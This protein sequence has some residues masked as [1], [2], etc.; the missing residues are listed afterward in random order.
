MRD[1]TTVI[2]SVLASKSH[3]MWFAVDITTPDAQTI[4]AC[5]I[6]ATV[7][8]LNLL[9]VSVEVD[10][11]VYPAILKEAPGVKLSRG[12]APSGG[13]MVLHDLDHFLGVLTGQIESILENSTV[14]VTTLWEKS[15]GTFE[16]DI[17][18]LGGIRD[19]KASDAETSFNLISDIDTRT[20]FVANRALT[21]RCL[22]TYGDDRCQRPAYLISPGETC[23]N[24]FDDAENGCL[25]KRWQFAFWGVPI[26]KNIS[27]S[28]GGTGWEPGGGGGTGGGGD[29]GCPSVRNYACV[30]DYKGEPVSMLVGDLKTGM[31]V[32]DA[33]GRR[34]RI[35]HIEFDDCDEMVCVTAANGYQT[36]C[37]TTEPLI[38]DI[39]DA[40]GRKA[41]ELEVDVDMLLCFDLD[42]RRNETSKVA[43]VEPIE[44]DRIAKITLSNASASLY[45]SGV[46][47][48]KMICRHNMA[49]KYE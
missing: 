8:S 41:S 25:A 29:P 49:R 38:R 33:L 19:V 22:A 5:E 45:L 7:T 36:E 13:T 35:D 40:S 32:Q 44:P 2:E 17:Y 23:S 1:L 11:V 6:E 26:L 28:L 14:V 10:P 48:K 18:F 42:T 43:S 24:I 20:F 16:A 21:Q 4:R 37:S 34:A 39:Y 31:I 27:G 9:G 15:D 12:K 46:D 30:I 3:N 47:K